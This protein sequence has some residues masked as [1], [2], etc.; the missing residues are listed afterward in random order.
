[1]STPWELADRAQRQLTQAIAEREAVA[2]MLAAIQEERQRIVST[3]MWCDLGD[4]AFSGRDRKRAT[5]KIE[6]IDEETGQPVEDTL[7]ACGQH[8]AERRALLR[9]KAIQD[10]P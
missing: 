8:A 7:T 6:T 10:G 9:P 4:H 1:M 2:R 3:A 5:Y